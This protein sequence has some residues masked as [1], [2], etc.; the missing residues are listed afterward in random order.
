MEEGT[1]RRLT[2]VLPAS[3]HDP[4]CDL[5]R[6]IF[7]KEFES[8]TP[9]ELLIV[10]QLADRFDVRN[11]FRPLIDVLEKDLS[12][13]VCCPPFPSPRCHNTARMFL[14]CDVR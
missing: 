2:V 5:I 8:K 6:F 11:A 12:F 10:L 13:D 3:E 1:S 9:D 7:Y 14:R 4:F